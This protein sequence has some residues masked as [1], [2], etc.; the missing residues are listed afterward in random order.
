MN[1]LYLKEKLL[2]LYIK[3]MVF[4]V[5]KKKNIKVVFVLN[6]VSVWKT[7]ALYLKMLQHSRFTPILA[8]SPS[9]EDPNA[10]LLMI[11]YLK[12][13]KYEFRMLDVSKTVVSQLHPDI[14]IYQ[15]PYE[16]CVSPMHIASRN[17]KVLMVYMPYGFTNVMEPWLY[18]EY[19][20]RYSWQFYHENEICAHATIMN[21]GHY[22]KNVIITGTPMMD[23]LIRPKEY[24]VNP[25]KDKKER[26]RII[27]APHHT[28]GNESHSGINYSTF[29]DYGEF[30]LDLAYKYKNETYWAFKPHPLLKKR[31]EA[32]WGIEKT[33]S[34]YQKWEELENAQVELGQYI[35]LFK[36]SN[37]MIHDCST[38]TQEYIYA[39]RPVM[40][41]LKNPHHTDNMNEFAK[42]TFALHIHGL[43]KTD[44]ENF[45]IDVISGVD[46]KQE[47]RNH[48]YE[49][50]MLPPHNKSACENIINAILGEQEYK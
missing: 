26:K 40:F 2:D 50:S 5:R 28:V 9:Q 18:E 36:H 13:K 30:I 42:A 3:L 49:T 44:I 19:L 11:E 35:G 24:Y 21:M 23:D 45:V 22:A 48:F 14:L 15:K 47:V 17:Y 43:N 33:N 37:A 38:F 12:N 27:Y 7:E 29:L 10:H 20:Y 31:L 32:V 6:T 16:T 34:Y 39:N 4:Y 25:W 1:L 41:L 8:I 46:Q